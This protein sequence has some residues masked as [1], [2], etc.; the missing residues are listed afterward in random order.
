MELKELTIKELL[1]DNVLVI[2]EIQREYVWGSNK[3]VLGKFLS[4]LNSSLGGISTAELQK[5]K[6]IFDD[7]DTVSAIRE[8]LNSSLQKVNNYYETNIGFL[9]SYDTGNN[10]HFIIDGQQRLTTIV[11]LA[12]YYAVKDE[13]ISDFKT[14]L[15]T[16]TPLMHFSYR[17]RP[18][19][20]QFLQN[21]FAGVSLD[22]LKNLKEAKWYVSDYDNDKT[23]ESICNL[24]KF[25]CDDK[26]SFSN[27]NYDS[28][29]QRVRFY[30]FDVRQTS[31]GEELYIT[32]NSRGEQ[33]KDSEQIKPYILEKMGKEERKVAAKQWDEWEEF[34][35]KKLKESG[36][37]IT[38][39]EVSAI[40]IAMDNIIKIALE[41]YGEKIETDKDRKREFDEIK[42]AEDSKRID[43]SKISTVV[44]NIKLLIDS[45]DDEIR[46]LGFVTFL[47]TKERTEKHL[48]LIESLIRAN[49]LEFDDKN[50]YRLIRLVNNSLSYGIINHVP[51][52]KFLSQLK[53]MEN[54]YQYINSHQDMIK[55]VFINEEN[56][57]E[58]EKI[59]AILAGVVTED[60]ID[61][62]E[63]T[64]FFDGRIHF[65]YRDA[66]GKLCWNGF[67]KKW[68]NAQKYFDENGVREGYR[69][70]ARLL[71]TFLSRIDVSGQWFGNNADFWYETLLNEQFK[72]VI[73]YL[74]TVNELQVKENCDEWIND[75]YLLEH[76][77]EEKDWWCLIKWGG[78]P[79]V[80]RYSRRVANPKSSREIV[81]LNSLRNNILQVKG[82]SI[83]ESQRIKDTSY[84]Y[85]LNINFSYEYEGKIYYFQWW[86]NSNETQLDVYLMEDEWTD[87]KKRHPRTYDKKTEEDTH[88]CFR[89]TSEME[90]DMSQFTKELDRLIAEA[91]SKR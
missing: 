8:K 78:Y 7:K 29:L 48:Y 66:E 37:V 75:D 6:P 77:L 82:I 56:T 3:E 71:R 45:K 69:K 40:D 25:I 20:E 39:N 13:R 67:G 36:K 24:Y 33:L 74:L 51:L 72:T 64:A 57:E 81:V 5:F 32:M 88:Y 34:F 10:E 42:A 22:I 76:L 9:Y 1:S 90:K 35:Y 89:V 28:L 49:E 47:F 15:K 30:Y 19:T 65:L 87:Y 12:Y 55:N 68:K 58:L 80:T 52:L 60:D 61:E 21:L 63:K 44:E 14:L 31:Q 46:K 91:S 41:L 59:K 18:L 86:G 85:G 17:V 73:H 84:L 53:R 2:P 83:Q 38:E 26:N 43:F 4:E 50:I 54:I 11:L 70:S 27:L 16:E 23:I 62:A 79:V